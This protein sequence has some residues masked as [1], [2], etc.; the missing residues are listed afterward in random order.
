MRVARLARTLS[1]VIELKVLMNSIVETISSMGWLLVLLCGFLYITAVVMTQV[2]TE[3]K[4]QADAKPSGHTSEL[5]LLY[6]GTLDSSFISFWMTVT[7]GIEWGEI[8]LPM[9]RDISPV[10][11][12]V[13][14]V[15]QA[16]ATLVVL[17][18]V[19]AFFIEKFISI[20]NLDRRSHLS[21]LLSFAFREG[22]TEGNGELTWHEFE[23]TLKLPMARQ[24]LQDL[25]VDIDDAVKLFNFLDFD[26]SGTVN[27]DELVHGAFRLMGNAKAIDLALFINDYQA[28]TQNVESCLQQLLSEKR[29]TTHV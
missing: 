13:F 7:E 3:Y 17:N 16:C 15:T 24:C 25:E 1:L 6:F 11:P 22:D 20:A 19:N 8:A 10:L 26:G 27:E 14:C 21:R 23:R 5:L 9:G 28:H 12:T 4:V 2:V 29:R 18:V